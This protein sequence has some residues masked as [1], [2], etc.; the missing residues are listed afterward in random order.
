MSVAHK[1]VLHFPPIVTE[2]PIVYLLARDYNLSFNILRASISPQEEGLMIL[3]LSG[4]ENDFNR[5]QDYLVGLGVNVQPLVQ[6]IRKN[7]ERC[8]DCGACIG[9]C[10]TKALVIE[11]PSMKVRFDPDECVACGECV[12][13]C[14]VRAM[15]LH[16]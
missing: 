13:T 11:R 5:A 3:E 8:V 4:E 15:E 1:V 10:P 16:F 9:V 14:M 7:D 2:Q 12:P 6:D